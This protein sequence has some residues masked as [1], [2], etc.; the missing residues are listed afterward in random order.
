LS[1]P[2]RYRDRAH[3]QF[4]ASQPCLL[5]GR[6]PTDAHHLRFAQPRA[7]GRRVSD[8]FAVPL[9]RIHHRVLHSRGDEE[10]WWKAVKFDPVIVARRLWDYTRLKG[11]PGH[12]RLATP[13][14]DASAPA[15]GDTEDGT[16]D[17][18]VD[19]K[20]NPKEPPA[21]PESQ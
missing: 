9:C 3:L 14:A 8:E 12:R 19:G 21:G 10:A 7:L 4:V 17:Q 20:S 13:L 15:A 5:C 11:A 16:V 6:R 1:E 2:R 18:N